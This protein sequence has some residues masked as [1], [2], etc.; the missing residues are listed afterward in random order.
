M[1]NKVEIEKRVKE[2]IFKF[3]AEQCSVDEASLNEETQIIE[4]LGGDSL[5]FVQLLES[6]KSKYNI[7]VEFRVIGRYMI[8][9]P[10][11]T[12]GDAISLAV[13]IITEKEKFA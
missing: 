1:E 6:W 7:E 9:N 3:F 2:D 12:L 8:N 5:M 13:Q 11:N 10:V 4:D